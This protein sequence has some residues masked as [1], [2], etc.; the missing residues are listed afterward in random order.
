MG[1]MAKHFSQ[2]TYKYITTPLIPHHFY[3]GICEYC[4]HFQG[5]F[6]ALDGKICVKKCQLNQRYSLRCQ[7]CYQQIKEKT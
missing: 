3:N 6:Q 2:T 7:F 5:P 4:S 1:F